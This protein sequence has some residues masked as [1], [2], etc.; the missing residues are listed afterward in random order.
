MRELE[1]LKG[2]GEAFRAVLSIRSL[3]SG[4]L[5]LDHIAE[6]LELFGTLYGWD[7]SMHEYFD[8]LVSSTY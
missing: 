6:N 8:A 4:I 7:L 1:R 2:G 3:N 5:F